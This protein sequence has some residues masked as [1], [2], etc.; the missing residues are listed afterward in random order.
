MITYDCE[1]GA[2]TISTEI[3]NM[4]NS[5]EI[6]TY[7]RILNSSWKYRVRNNEVLHN[8]GTNSHLVDSTAK[9]DMSFYEFFRHICKGLSGGELIKR[10]CKWHRISWRKMKRMDK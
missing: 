3:R 8:M 2:W 10:E 9:N 7:R 5:F 6:W 4:I 1:L